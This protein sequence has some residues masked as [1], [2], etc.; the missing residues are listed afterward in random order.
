M[1]IR[2]LALF[3][4]LGGALMA[5][6]C[7]DDATNGTAGSGGEGGSGGDGAG[8]SGGTVVADPGLYGFTCDS[9]ALPIPLPVTIRINADDPGFSEGAESDLTTLL[10]YTVAPDIIELLPVLAPGAM[11]SALSATV[12]VAGGTPAAIEHGTADPL[13][14]APAAE[15]DS[16]TLITPVTPTSTSVELSVTS[17]TAT[18]NGLGDLVPGGEVDI[19]AGADGC[20]AVE[21]AEGSGPLTFDVAGAG[22]TGGTGGGTGGTG[23]GTGGTGGQN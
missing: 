19:T 11:I 6:G 22:G 12:S 21:A 23:G 13:P 15:F 3:A 14:I 20:T 8:G 7:G 4:L 18:I 10:N 17:F 1:N 2:K 9:D 16:D 5:F